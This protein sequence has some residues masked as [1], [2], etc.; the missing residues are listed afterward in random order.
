VLFSGRVRFCSGRRAA[1]NLRPVALDVQ[2]IALLPNTEAE[3]NE[4]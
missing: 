4:G 3:P 1:T 2:L